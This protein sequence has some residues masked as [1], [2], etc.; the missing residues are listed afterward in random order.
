MQPNVIIYLNFWFPINGASSLVTCR[1]P[2]PDCHGNAP[3][4]VLFALRA[5]HWNLEG[6]GGSGMAFLSH[7]T[8]F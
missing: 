1:T 7:Q 4:D 8:I 5:A 2:G 6:G 3:E